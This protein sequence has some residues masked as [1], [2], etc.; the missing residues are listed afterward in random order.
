MKDARFY[1]EFPSRA[2]KKR[3]G[4]AHTGHAGNVFALNLEAQRMEPGHLEGV[5]AVFSDP[6][7]PCASTGCS[8]EWLAQCKRVPE[9][10]ARAIHPRLFEY[11]EPAIERAEGR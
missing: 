9:R 7:S 2:A 11:L 1:L 3:S 4:K 8:R 10:T 5:G 6:N